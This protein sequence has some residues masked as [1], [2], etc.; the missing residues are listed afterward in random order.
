M[1]VTYSALCWTL[2]PEKID[3]FLAFFDTD[4]KGQHSLFLC[5]GPC[6]L[7]S[8]VV[9]HCSGDLIFHCEQLVYSVIEK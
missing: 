6:H 5:G 3:L 1:Q 7:S 9:E 4:L 8:F 2:S